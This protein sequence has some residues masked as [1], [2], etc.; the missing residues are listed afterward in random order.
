MRPLGARQ[1]L[2]GYNAIMLRIIEQHRARIDELCQR[3]GVKRL[4]LFGSAARGDFN[5]KTSDLDFFV[6]FISED[7]HGAADRW[8]GLLE[9]LEAVFGRKVDLGSEEPVLPEGGE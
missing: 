1:R 4:D 2:N 9:G 6:E 3:Y 7:W 8:F 5:E